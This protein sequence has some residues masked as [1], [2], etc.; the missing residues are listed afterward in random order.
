MPLIKDYNNTMRMIFLSTLVNEETFSSTVLSPVNIHL[1]GPHKLNPIWIVYRLLLREHFPKKIS[2]S[3]N[4]RTQRYSNTHVIIWSNC[5]YLELFIEN[6]KVLWLVWGN[7]SCPLTSIK[8]QIKKFSDKY[9]CQHVASS[10][11]GSRQWMTDLIPW[12]E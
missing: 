1:N 6:K 5:P 7:M 12:V 2:L 8:C 4:I 11:N 10:L 3:L 9:G